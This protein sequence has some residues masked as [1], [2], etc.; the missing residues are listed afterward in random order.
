MCFLFVFLT[1]PQTFFQFKVKVKV[2][3]HKGNVSWAFTP[4][5]ATQKNISDTRH[6]NTYRGGTQHYTDSAQ[7]VLNLPRMRWKFITFMHFVVTKKEQKLFTSFM[8]IYKY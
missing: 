5:A 4:A 3:V 8:I 7:I 1:F 6:I 2:I